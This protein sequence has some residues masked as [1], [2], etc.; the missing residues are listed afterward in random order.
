[1]EYFVKERHT[2]KE[3]VY[4]RAHTLL[5][6]IIFTAVLFIGAIIFIIIGTSLN[7]ANS[8]VLFLIF[9][10][11]SLFLDFFI[12]FAVIQWFGKGWEIYKKTFMK[13]NIKVTSQGSSSQIINIPKK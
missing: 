2:N 9:V 3:W 1:M 11:I 7:I 12:A 8:P 6:G 10:I 4:E 5:L 13:K